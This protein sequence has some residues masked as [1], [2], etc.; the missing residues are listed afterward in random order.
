MPRHTPISKQDRVALLAIASIIAI[1]GLIYELILG[2]ASSYLFGDSIVSFSLGIG[3]SLFGMGIGSL[4]A[5]KLLP[6]SERRFMQNELFLSLIGGYSVVILFAAYSY[7]RLYWLV[8]VVLSVVI[9]IC[10]G[11]EIPLVV[12]TYKK[13]AKK[14]SS[15]FLSNILAVDYI[16]ALVGSLLFPFI[17][18]PYLGLVRTALAVGT[19]NILVVVYLAWRR[20]KEIGA[21]MRD[22][23][24]VVVALLIGGLILSTRIER[25]LTTANFNDPVVYFELSP[26]QRI[27]L[28]QYKD[29]TRLYLNSHLQFSTVD[30]AR[31]HETLA[32]AAMS[33]TSKH[34]SVLILGGGDGLLTREIL[35]YPDV[36]D[37]TLVDLDP[38]VTNF[39]R[40]N[41]IMTDI[42][43]Q[44][45]SSDKVRIVNEDAFTWLRDSRES[46]D[47][48][49]VDLIDPANEKIAKLYTVEFYDIAR[50]HLVDDGA[51][52]TQASSTFFTPRSFWSIHASIEKVF[53]R[54]TPMS[55]NI[56]S[57]GEWGFVMTSANA[58]FT[59]HDMPSD[60]EFVSVDSLVRATQLLPDTLAEK[61]SEYSTLLRPRVYQFYNQDLSRWSY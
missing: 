59:Q 4:L 57:F 30:E 31:Y 37:V 22:M 23:I 19:L 17:L 58:P 7:T 51:F 15:T 13:I 36:K 45:L 35:K 8:F 6:Q 25:V 3:L 48:I 27:V 60:R 40:S 46:Y 9:G 54:A 53:S 47:V 50:D 33:T 18:L 10:I 26:Y 1:G 38:A 52:I 29:D 41:P 43:Q 20:R 42:N 55:V 5:I 14:D 49:L 12:D 39:A 44:S 28:T 56:P 34:D 16:G 2:T 24:I 32:H 61:H 21:G 11:L